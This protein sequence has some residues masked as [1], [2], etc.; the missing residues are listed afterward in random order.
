MQQLL[1]HVD[2]LEHAAE[3]DSKPSRRTFHHIRETRIRERIS[4]RTA[5]KRLGLT[6]AEAGR[7]EAP[8]RDLLLSEVHAWSEALRVPPNELAFGVSDDQDAEVAARA[9]MVKIARL[10]HRLQTRVPHCGLRKRAAAMLNEII[11]AMPEVQ[12]LSE[13]WTQKRRTRA[14]Q[15]MNCRTLSDIAQASL[16]RVSRTA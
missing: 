1:E 13:S 5:A 10:L 3:Q 2:T 7:H 8:E 14:E 9:G 4:L 11:E 15:F 6:T 12:A 16:R